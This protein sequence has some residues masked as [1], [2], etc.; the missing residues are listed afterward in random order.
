MRRLSSRRPRPRPRAS[1]VYI[2]AATLVAALLLIVA[3]RFAL[4]WLAERTIAHV[5]R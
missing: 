2:V 5:W 3:S 4:A 1:L